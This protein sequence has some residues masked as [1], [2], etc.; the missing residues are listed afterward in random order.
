[1][2]IKIEKDGQK[3]KIALEPSTGVDEAFQLGQLQQELV[4]AEINHSHTKSP[5]TLKILLGEDY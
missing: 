2:I 4:Q 5:I 3:T 1:M